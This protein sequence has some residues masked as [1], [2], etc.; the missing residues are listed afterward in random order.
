MVF[1]KIDKA[2]H[3]SIY[4]FLTNVGWYS[5]TNMKLLGIFLSVLKNRNKYFNENNQNVFSAHCQ[6]WKDATII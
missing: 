6:D 4:I 3:S 2:G 1:P 5:Y